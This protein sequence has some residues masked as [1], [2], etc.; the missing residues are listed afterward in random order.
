MH[1]ACILFVNTV[2]EREPANLTLSLRNSTT[3]VNETFSVSCRGYGNELTITWWKSGQ[4][5]TDDHIEQ[6]YV[7]QNNTHQFIESILTI[8]SVQLEDAGNYS[9]IANNSNGTERVDFEVRVLLPSE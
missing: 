9:C 8:S 5:L 6:N 1:R 4:Q 3:V 2:G 7:P